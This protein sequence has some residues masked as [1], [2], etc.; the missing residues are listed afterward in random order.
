M[1]IGNTIAAISTAPGSAPRAMVRISGPDTPTIAHD[2][3]G[4]GFDQRGATIARLTLSDGLSLPVLALRYPAPSSY[5][6]EDTI[7]LLIPGGGPI[8][9][10]VLDRI[11]EDERVSLAEP[12][13][14]SAR[15]YMNGRL[16]LSEA[17]GVALRISALGQSAL[18]AADALLDGRYGAQCREWVDELASLLALVEAG[19]DF[20]DQEDVVPI[21]PRDLS[22][23]LRVL[24]EKL[25]DQAGSA[26]GG[27]ADHD[28]PVVVLVGRPNAGKSTLFNALLGRNRAVV[29]DQAG[30]TRDALREPLDL[31][32]DV[33]GAGVVELVDLAGLDETSVDEIDA[34]AQAL[35]RSIVAGADTL[36]WCDASGRFDQGGFEIPSGSQVIRVRTK[37]DLPHVPDIPGNGSASVEVSAFDTSTLGVLRR[38]IADASCRASGTGVGVFVP[39]HRRALRDA[40]RSIGDA[41][42]G[43]D[44]R[45]HALL[46]PE[47]TA[48]C[49]REALDALGELVGE[50]SPDDVI[51]RVFSTFCVG[52]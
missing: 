32:R 34:Q 36:L 12:G 38:A 35:A 10:R 48:L 27:R 47:L 3:L 29:S 41:I 2:L 40:I 6:G 46:Q 14:F 43:I 23:R 52:K 4:L 45:A 44:P 31:A 19:V 39:R 49:L 50:V 51:G 37:S 17:E 25:L 15:A 22:D 21:A 13:A 42:T 28:R 18:R 16:S 24:E 11:L 7:E 30:T 1:P 26:S 5:S 33:P 20:S 9:Q 8:A